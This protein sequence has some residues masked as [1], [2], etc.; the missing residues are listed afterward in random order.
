[1]ELD[2]GT[3]LERATRLGGI[4]LSPASSIIPSFLIILPFLFL[5]LVVFALIG[6]WPIVIFC[7]ERP[8]LR[9]DFLI[10]ILWDVEKG[11]ADCSFMRLLK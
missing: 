10:V 2:Q 1:M 3:Y 11:F 5:F 8:M 4:F 9:T 7:R 6:C